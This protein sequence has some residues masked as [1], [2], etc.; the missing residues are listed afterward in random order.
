M[1]ACGGSITP[2]NGANDGD[3]GGGGGAVVPDAVETD[4]QDQVGEFMAAL[5]DID[6]R[7]NVGLNFQPYSGR[8]AMPAWRTNASM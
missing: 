7:L 5:Q 4:C 2:G 6:G 1:S 8:S 3:G